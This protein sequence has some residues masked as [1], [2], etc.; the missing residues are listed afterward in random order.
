[1]KFKINY[2]AIKDYLGMTFGA[3]IFAVAYSW[4]LIPYKMT[5][6]GVGGLGQIFYHFFGVP[7]GLFMILINI[8]LFII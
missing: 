2:K 6:G 3:V 5:P 7:V 1:M 8:P 4:F